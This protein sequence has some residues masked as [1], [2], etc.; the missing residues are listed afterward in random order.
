[1]IG[2]GCED[3]C[4][5]VYATQQDGGHYVIQEFSCSGDAYDFFCAHLLTVNKRK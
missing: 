4:W 5:K 2:C 1:V 3:G